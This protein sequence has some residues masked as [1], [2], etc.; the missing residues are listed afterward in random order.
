MAAYRFPKFVRVLTLPL[1]LCAV[2][3]AQFKPGTPFSAGANPNSIAIADFNRDGYPDLAITDPS[4]TIVTVLFG[5][6]AGKFTTPGSTFAVGQH[7]TFLLAGDFNKDGYPDLV[8]ANELDNTI[9]VLLNDKMGGFRAL[10]IRRASVR[11][12][13]PPW[14]TTEMA[15]RISRLP[16]GSEIQ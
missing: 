9:T 14:I 4:L 7:P 13:S 15:I 11:F 5:I 1:A 10:L 2:G 3:H 6:G 16:T 12:S 8:V